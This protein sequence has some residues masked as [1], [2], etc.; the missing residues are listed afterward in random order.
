LDKRVYAHVQGRIFAP[1]Y[2]DLP[3]C[4]PGARFAFLTPNDVLPTPIPGNTIAANFQCNIPIGAKDGQKFRPAV[5][6]HGL[7]G[8]ADEVNSGKLYELGKY[9][10]MLCATDE[11]GMAQE[12]IPNGVATLV[13]VSNFPSMPA[14]LQQGMI[15]FLYLGRAFI[16]PSGF[17]SN[18][19]FQVNGHCVIDTSHLYY[20]G[21]SQGA[22]FGGALAAIDPDFTRAHIGVAGMNYSILLTRSSDF[23]TYAQVMYRTYTD[24]LERQ[25]VLSF[26]QNLWDHGEANGYAQHMTTDPPADTPA[27]S[28]LMTVAFGDHQVTNWASEVEARTIGARIR[29]PLLDPGRYPGPHPWWGVLR[30]EDD[31]YPYDGPAALVL[32]DVGPLRDCPNDGVTSCSGGKAGTTPPPLDNNANR[33][34]IDPHGPDWAESPE[35]IFAIGAWLRVDGALPAVCGGHP[36]YIAGWTGP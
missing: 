26:I 31:A 21:G 36:C 33:A 6:G 4:P 34:G 35:G 24:P 18:A 19:A 11:I 20:D 1:C 13:N 28:V 8:T 2:L 3:G 25:L 7:F 30:I 5:Y 17:C 9:G 15:N 10:L 16:N 12:D 23:D 32:A 14:R 27:H 29:A 22:I